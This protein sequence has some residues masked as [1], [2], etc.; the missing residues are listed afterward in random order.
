MQVSSELVAYDDT[1]SCRASFRLRTTGP[2]RVNALVFPLV[3]AA[4]RL[5]GFR[6]ESQAFTMKGR[7]VIPAQ[8]D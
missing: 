7:P 5:L 6:Q 4:L 1:N 3:W 2:T 8:V